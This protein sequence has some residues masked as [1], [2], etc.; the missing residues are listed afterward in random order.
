MFAANGKILK[1]DLRNGKHVVE[2]LGEDFYKKW[3]GGY[4]LGVRVVYEYM[5]KGADPL[6]PENVIG[7]TTGL[8]AGLVPFGGSF[9]V[10]GKS[11]L[12]GGW[13]DARGGGYFGP[14][15]KKA[16]YDAVFIKG[17]SDKPVYV[18]ID[19]DKVEV[20]DATY[21]WG[22]NTSETEDMIKEELGDE[23][24]QVASIGQ[25]GENLCR[26]A[27]IV[28]DKGRAA[29]RSGLGAV[30]GSKKLKA[31]AVRGYKM[32]EV[33][34][35]EKLRELSKTIIK[36]GRK[37]DRWKRLSK[38][39]TSG[40]M[41]NALTVGDAPVKNWGGAP[42]DFPT[43]EK[44]SDESVIKYEV[45]KYGC[46]GCPVL[47]G[48]IVEVKEGKWK[49]VGHKPEYETLAALG[50]LCLN[51]DVESIIYMN[52]Q[53][54]MYGLDT[55]SVGSVIAFAMECY[56]KGIISKEDTG[57]L[58]LSWGNSEAM[59]QLI[60]MIAFRRGFGDILA[61]GSK[62]AA[63]RM[64]KGSESYAMH[65]GGQDLPMHD[66]R[67][68]LDL[69]V[70]YVANA[71]PARH[72]QGTFGYSEGNASDYIIPGLGS[73]ST[74]G[75]SLAERA[76]LHA[77][78]TYRNHATQAL[79]ICNFHT[80][81]G[82]TD[83][84]TSLDLLNAATGWGFTMEDYLKVGERIATMRHAFNAREGLR[85]KDFKLP[86]RIVG[87]PPMSYGPHKGKIL[88]VYENVRAYFEYEEWDYETGKP[89][90]RKLLEL[91]LDDVAKDLWL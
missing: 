54:N 30:M 73:F 86:D 21:L 6:S 40:G 61:D 7:F 26:I 46:R 27:C 52:H 91:G 42:E 38:Y 47:C 60:E 75:L 5:V 68:G 32:P 39:G 56:E 62:F 37:K 17:A 31:V 22:R 1:I 10:V 76:K 70:T 53:C 84:P 85:P 43:V 14:E 4:G 50:S 45:K 88:N 13:G 82:K 83:V 57:G 44:I 28:T 24:I 29:G 59:S 34:D 89:K 66:P 12:T 36:L 11:P 20:R 49:V 67:W 2:E 51:D 90:K 33:Y 19:G 81:A 65:V 71:T 23:K 18:W 8:L 63:E 80:A 3:F 64:G 58:D 15:L 69:G 41:A 72:T 87:N 55:I 78:A 74:E 48:G 77:L 79:G 25:A 35:P 9:T 16:G